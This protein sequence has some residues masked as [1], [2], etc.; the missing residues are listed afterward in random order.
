MGGPRDCLTPMLNS[1]HSDALMPS[2]IPSSLSSPRPGK[3]AP[4]QL[5]KVKNKERKGQAV[6]WRNLLTTEISVIYSC[7]G[8]ACSWTVKSVLL[9]KRFSRKPCH[10]P[11][12]LSVKIIYLLTRRS[13]V[14]WKKLFSCNL[15]LNLGFRKK[16]R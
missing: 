11:S 5:P 14:N 1:L 2:L 6:S 8:G 15:Q 12:A 10:L 4:I 13:F 16:N 3:L 7:L 9:S